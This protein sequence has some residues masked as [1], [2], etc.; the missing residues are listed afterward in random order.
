LD[1]ESIAQIQVP[2][3]NLGPWGK[4]LHQRGERVY[5]EDLLD[6][7]PRYLFGLLYRFDELL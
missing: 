3:V 4:E 7:I 2:A 5:T 1:L 6:T